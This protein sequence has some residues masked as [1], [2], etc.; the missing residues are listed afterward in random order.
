MVHHIIN[1]G[2]KRLKATALLPAIVLVAG[3]GYPLL[4]TIGTAQ[5]APNTIVTQAAPQDWAFADD[6][7]NG[8]SGDF[9]N[10]PATPP[11]G[12]GSAQL[13]ITAANQGYMFGKSA[14]GGT[15]LSSITKLGYSTYNQQGNNTEAI[16]LQL[17]IDG[18]TTDSNTA[19]Q[20]RLVYEPYY[21]HTVTDGT[22]QTW[23]TL[24][25]TS[26]S[27]HGNWWFSN[28]TL[29]SQT[30]CTQAAPC[31]WSTVLQKLPDA[32]IDSGA[33]QG[34]VF[35]AG[36][37]WAVPYTG[38]I[39]AFTLGISGN[40]TTFNFDKKNCIPVSTS[41]GNLT[42]AQVGGN[43]TGDLDAHS[44]DIGVYYD[45]S[46]QG[47]VKNAT[48]HDADHYGVFADGINGNVSLDVTKSHVYAIGDHIN[49]AYA[50]SGVQTGVAVYYNTI[51]YQNGNQPTSGK[52]SGEVSYDQV[53]KYQKGGIVLNGTKTDVDID[54]NVVSGAG[55]VNYIA[56]NGIQVS[57]GAT[58]DVTDNTVGDNAY[59]GHNDATSAGILIY[60]G[61]G[62]P[63]TRG[64]L[65]QDNKL[66]DND[67][68]INFA[69]YNDDATDATATTTK[70]VAKDNWIYSGNV[71]NVSGLGDPIGYQVGIEDVG[72]KDSA[73]N[74][75]II[76]QGYADQGSYDATTQ[77]ATPGPDGA[78]VRDID[79]GYTFPTTDFSTCDHGGHG[80]GHFNSNFF[81][82]YRGWKSNHYWDYR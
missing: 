39:D 43:V 49:N 47:Q 55:P 67:E 56:Q 61:W 44:C 54:N 73:C 19:W 75:T 1:R 29:S 40:D 72:N 76:G 57:R 69:N 35:K 32:G 41:K 48:I 63:V 11:L 80:G 26:Q 18:D 65:V 25:N 28:G 17:N 3:A 33:S 7:G 15:K 34:I 50:P 9:V 51:N 30:G 46:H 62:D 82:H 77:T 60:G 52:I 31:T 68:G 78:V 79:A 71:T 64:V 42:A 22:W 66:V 12:T 16:A 5:A 20:G 21:T 53:N 70:N 24:D 37:N 38:N 8:G 2:F 45:H 81:K 58:S 23:N 59:T 10:G 4:A 13:A 36:S 6:N 74:N 14:Y 27:G